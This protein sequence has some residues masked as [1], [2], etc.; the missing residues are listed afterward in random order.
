MRFQNRGS[1][2]GDAIEF[3]MFMKELEEDGKKKNEPDVEAEFKKWKE[4]YDK[5][6]DKKKKRFTV[7]ETFILLLL[8]VPVVGPAYFS[9]IIAMWHLPIYLMK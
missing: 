4:K 3:W 9:I 7:M 2:I 6:Q 8:M 5:E 1:S